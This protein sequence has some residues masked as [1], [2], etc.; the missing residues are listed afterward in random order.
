MFTSSSFASEI[1]SK[2]YVVQRMTEILNKKEFTAAKDKIRKECKTSLIVSGCILA[3]IAL[4]LA[5]YFAIAKHQWLYGIIVLIVGGLIYLIVA[6]NLINIAKNKYA[7]LLAPQIIEALYGPNANYQ[8]KGGYSRAYLEG[9]NLFPVRNLDQED[10]IEGHYD[11]VPF[12]IADVNSW[13]WETRG[14]G[15]NQHQERVTDFLGC[16][17]SFRMNKDSKY[18]LKVVD[19]SNLF[20]GNTIDF[21]SVEFNKKFNVYCQDREQAFYIITPQ[22]QLA[23]LD[24]EKALPG[25]ITFL[26]RGNELV[27]VISGN[28]TEF[29][30]VNL[31]KGDNYN[32]NAILDSILGPAFIT[33]SLN[34]DHKFFINESDINKP[35]VNT[36]DE[37]IASL[38]KQLGEDGKELKKEIEDVKEVI[39]NSD[40]IE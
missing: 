24:I 3:A 12:T 40:N 19:G 8:P 1:K 22:L 21:E 27:V 2:P 28:T 29:A 11:G 16:V 34:L 9:I 30:G 39:N 18:E 36:D 33:D 38:T 15:K 4:I 35:I 25:G 5:I 13:H 7:S 23:M 32:I 26:F 20:K 6:L 31:K 17:M 10:L 14:S 37:D